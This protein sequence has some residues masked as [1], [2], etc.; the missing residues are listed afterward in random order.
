MK[1]WRREDRKK[2][3]AEKKRVRIKWKEERKRRRESNKFQKGR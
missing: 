3:K 2:D 1:N